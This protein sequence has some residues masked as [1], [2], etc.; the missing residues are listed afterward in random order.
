MESNDVTNKT[1]KTDASGKKAKKRM[2]FV[3]FQKK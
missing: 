2:V 1:P 3:L